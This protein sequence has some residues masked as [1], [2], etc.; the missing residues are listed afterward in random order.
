MEKICEEIMDLKKKG[1]YYLMYQKAQELEGRTSK[2]IRTFGLEDNLG[3]LVTV[4][5][6][7][8]RMWQKYMQDLYD[9]ENHPKIL[10]LK[11]KRKW[12]KMTKG[13]L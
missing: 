1:R 4:H 9:S 13:L 6:K 10:Q 7:Y 3:S 2:L 12:M 5:R 11:E 8:L